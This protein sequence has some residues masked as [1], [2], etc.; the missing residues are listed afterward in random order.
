MMV[1]KRGGARL[2]AYVCVRERVG[3]SECDGMCASMNVCTYDVCM[4][5]CIQ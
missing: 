3:V 4:H 1:I 5:E 2:C